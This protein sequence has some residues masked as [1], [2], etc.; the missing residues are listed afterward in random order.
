MK[1]SL[2]ISAMLVVYG[3]VYVGSLGAAPLPYPWLDADA[4]TSRSIARTIPPPRHA[5]RV[6]TRAGS[7]ADWLRGLPLRPAK[8]QVHLYDGRPKPYQAGQVA[9]VDLDTGARDLQQCA[10]AVIRLRAEYLW[11]AKAKSRVAFDLTNGMR[12]DWHRW[13]KGERVAVTGNK[14]RWT[15]GGKALATH[16]AF[17]RYLN[18]IFSYAGSASLEREL[19]PRRPDAVEAGDVLIQGGHPGHAVLVLDVARDAR[20]NRYVLLGQSFMP[21]QD[22]HVLAN[23]DDAKLSPWYRIDSLDAGLQTPEWGPFRKKDLKRFKD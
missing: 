11:A 12:V 4:D 5:M 14:T 2:L 1:L 22:F 16:A 3:G 19:L 15:T 9:V 10:D 18:F 7:F 21:A 17:R 20:G 13:A 23:P 6:A 8:T